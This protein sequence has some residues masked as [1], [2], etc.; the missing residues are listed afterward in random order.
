M[1][2]GGLGGVHR[3]AC[4]TFDISADLDELAR[5]DGCAVVCSGVKS[6]LDIALTLGVLVVIFYASTIV[7]FGKTLETRR[8]QVEQPKN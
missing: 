4:E 1:A 6:I 8:M 3:G 7:R 5:A 2:T